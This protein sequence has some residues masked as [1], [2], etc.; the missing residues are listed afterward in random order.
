MTC[1]EAVVDVRHLAK[2]YGEVT[3]V[4]DISLRVGRGEIFGFLGPNGAGKTTC[5]K[6]LV[7]LVRPTAGA[8]TLLGSPLGVRSARAKLGYLPELFRY[9]EWL[10]ARE[11]LRFHCRLAQVARPGAAIAHVLDVVGLSERADHR[12]GTY[13]KGMQQ[14]LGLAV[15]LLN[16][17]ELVVLDEPTSAL[18]PIGRRDVRAILRDL[19]ARGTA[20]FLNSHLLT[21]VEHVCDRVAI[22]SKGAVVAEGSIAEVVGRQSSV[23]VRAS[24]DGT[25]IES[26]LR[27]FGTVAQEGDAFVVAGIGREDVPQLVRA[28]VQERAQIFAV[29]PISLSLEERF[30]QIA[31]D[32][33]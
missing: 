31:D 8:G 15:A 16:E 28:L 21:E 6:M 14:R 1:T 13:S 17:P 32:V 25:P 22:V 24:A 33:R 12:V 4:E 23:R 19:K 2:T 5:V 18:D 30:L 9:Q 10:S 27:R 7:G 11:V 29:E 26:V 20:V 3:A